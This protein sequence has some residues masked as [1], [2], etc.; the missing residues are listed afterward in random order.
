MTNDQDREKE[1]KDKEILEK[2]FCLKPDEPEEPQS[3]KA[4]KSGE[5]GYKPFSLQY[6][7]CHDSMDLFLEKCHVCGHELIMCKKYGGQCRS[8]KCKA[9]R[10]KN[11][12]QGEHDGS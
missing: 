6:R 9:G 2:I 4:W 11:I 10:I 7:E 1:A 3:W 8:S 12:K 5:S